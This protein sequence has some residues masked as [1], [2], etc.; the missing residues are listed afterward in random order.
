MKGREGR[1]FMRGHG[2][3]DGEEEE[4]DAEGHMGGREWGGGGIEVKG[5]QV[6]GRRM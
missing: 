1:D 4:E 6:K 2:K 3:V 5:S